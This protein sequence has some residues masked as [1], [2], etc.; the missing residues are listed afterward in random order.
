MVDD[1]VV[2]DE[3]AS[4]VIGTE[5]KFVGSGLIDGDESGDM[6]K[7]IVFKSA[8]IFVAEFDLGDDDAVIGGLSRDEL[9]NLVHVDPS[10]VKAETQSGHAFFG[11]ILRLGR[12][13]LGIEI[14]IVIG[15][16]LDSAGGAADFVKDTEPGRSIA[17]LN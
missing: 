14:A 2:A 9:G 12:S 5:L 16:L 3:E 6:G 4:S 13:G 17:E 15:G 11:D 7:E 10:V 8:P 1:E